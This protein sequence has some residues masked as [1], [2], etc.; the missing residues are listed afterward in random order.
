MPAVAVAALFAAAFAL[1]GAE[2]QQLS[3]AYYDGS[4]PHVY[5]T[6][7]RVIQEARAS[8]PRIL[9]SLLRL[10]FHDCFVNVRA[11]RRPCMALRL[12]IASRARLM[13]SCWTA[14]AGL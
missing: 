1:G 7:R 14:R 13:V 10:H 11:R 4:C 8:D 9:A 2:A 12:I 5:D 3:P 6:V